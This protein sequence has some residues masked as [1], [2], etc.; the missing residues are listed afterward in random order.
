VFE[1]E[2]GHS[3]DHSRVIV[4]LEAGQTVHCTGNQHSICVVDMAVCMTWHARDSDGRSF[5]DYC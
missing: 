3:I 1:S 2:S 4:L 5:F